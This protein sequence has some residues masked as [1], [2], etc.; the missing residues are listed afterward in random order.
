VVA[1]G[2]LW[3]PHVSG[4]LVTFVA[5]DDWAAGRDVQKATAVRLALDALPDRPAVR[6]LTW[7]N[8]R[9]GAGRHFRLAQ[10]DGPGER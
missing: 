6:P 8:G 2:Y 3:F 4:D 10:A 7:V 1:P 9:H 5:S